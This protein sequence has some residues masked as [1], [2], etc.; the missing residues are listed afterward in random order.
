M[1]Y[2]HIVFKTRSW[3]LGFIRSCFFLVRNISLPLL[4]R[5]LN[6]LLSALEHS[7]N[8]RQ[9]DKPL[10]RLRIDYT[11]GFEPFSGYR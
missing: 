10:V 1:S 9:P 11:G 4:L 7:G 5:S 8:R 3:V 6:F 2:L